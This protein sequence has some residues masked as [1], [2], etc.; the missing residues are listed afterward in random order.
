M[1]YIT[2]GCSRLGRVVAVISMSL[3]LMIVTTVPSHAVDDVARLYLPE[4]VAP[5]GIGLVF[6][7][8]TID[9]GVLES[10]PP[11]P[12]EPRDKCNKSDGCG[13]RAFFSK[14]FAQKSGII[15]WVSSQFGNSDAYPTPY[16]AFSETPKR[17]LEAGTGYPRTKIS[18]EFPTAV[19]A[20]V[21]ID[22]STSTYEW[23]TCVVLNSNGNFN[24][25]CNGKSGWGITGDYNMGSPDDVCGVIIEVNI[26]GVRTV[27]ASSNVLERPDC[28]TPAVYPVAPSTIIE[29]KV[30]NPPRRVQVTKTCIIPAGTTY[31]VNWTSSNYTRTGTTPNLTIPE[32]TNVNHKTT[33]VAAKESTMNKDGTWEPSAITNIGLP[34]QGTIFDYQVPSSAYAPEAPYRD[35]FLTEFTAGMDIVKDNGNGYISCSNTDCSTYTTTMAQVDNG[36]ITQAQSG[37]KCTLGG[38]D[39]PMSECRYIATGLTAAPNANVDYSTIDDCGL[40]VTCYVE[41]L[42]TPTEYA[43]EA[44]INSITTAFNS[45]ALG[46][47]PQA[48]S[49]FSSPFSINTNVP[50][51][52][53]CAGPTLTLPKNMGVTG[54]QVTGNYVIQP[55]YACN[56]TQAGQFG[57]TISYYIRGILAPTVYI[58]GSYMIVNTLLASIGMALPMFA[59]QEDTVDTRTGEITRGRR[60]R[61]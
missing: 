37:Y 46:I 7:S 53:N 38:Y 41:A 59:R 10:I 28:N 58:A 16:I 22:N 60:G 30:P 19:P 42:F 3:T 24:K 57:A 49:D 25:S 2:N 31:T 56:D 34:T 40:S 6:T 12:D 32:C 13:L 15:K 47:I 18:L 55:L 48:I 39:I 14:L 20:G 54:T 61:R 8:P 45:S 11:T 26:S 50:N 5:V 4:S 29:T 17:I 21:T 51:Q 9:V 36:T 27:V 35:L 1:R 23:Y 52:E 44:R 43:A 33:G